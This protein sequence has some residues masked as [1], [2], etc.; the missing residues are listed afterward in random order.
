MTSGINLPDLPPLN[1]EQVN[2]GLQPD[3]GL[4]DTWFQAFVKHNAN[5]VKL[6]TFAEQ[7]IS[8]LTSLENTT[9]S[10]TSEITLIREQLEDINN[11]LEMLFDRSEL[12]Q[13]LARLHA[14]EVRVSSIPVSIYADAPVALLGL[15]KL[16]HD[17]NDSIKALGYGISN[18][19]YSIKGL[20]FFTG[21]KP[22]RV[23]MYNYEW[24][25]PG[26]DQRV[27]TGETVTWY[28]F[29]SYP[30]RAAD[31][32]SVTFTN[33]YTGSGNPGVVGTQTVLPLD[34]NGSPISVYSNTATYSTGNLVADDSDFYANA[35]KWYRSKTNSNTGNALT[36]T[37]H[38]E[39]V[40]KRASR[41]RVTAPV[42][43]AGGERYVKLGFPT[44][45][46][47]AENLDGTG[48]KAVMPCL[49]RGLITVVAA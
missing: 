30:V 27:N 49:D 25:E 47:I 5:M 44:N 34:A 39:E 46:Q 36:N 33:Q 32:A 19:P 28:I 40:P 10:L 4:G 14:L 17:T 35:T 13:I 20:G 7:S 45:A 18:N 22:I 26:Q 24:M 38:W 15:G 43:S 41:F 9:S 23:L 12:E 11:R 2:T 21:G 31:V 3:D 8:R 29:F 42:T 1:L 6:A 37:T 48:R 16:R